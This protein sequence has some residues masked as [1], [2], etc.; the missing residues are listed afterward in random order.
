MQTELILAR[1]HALCEQE[2]ADTR[3]TSKPRVAAVLDE[4]GLDGDQ[5]ADR[6]DLGV[7]RACELVGSGGAIHVPGPSAW[8]TRNPLVLVI[9]MLHQ[10]H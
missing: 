8:L 3:W 5:D 7:L 6:P 2:A 9:G 4:L 1:D 10:P